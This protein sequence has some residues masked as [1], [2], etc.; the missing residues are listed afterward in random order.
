MPIS[1]IQPPAL[2]ESAPSGMSQVASV[3]GRLVIV[4]GQVAPSC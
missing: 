3:R 2:F 1:F 4:S